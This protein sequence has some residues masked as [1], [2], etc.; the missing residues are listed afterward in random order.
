MDNKIKK[1]TPRCTLCK[2][3][4]SSKDD[5]GSG[6]CPKCTPY[7][8]KEELNMDNQEAQETQVNQETHEAQDTQE[9][10]I[11]DMA[12]IDKNLTE[13]QGDVTTEQKENDTTE[14]EKLITPGKRGVTNFQ[15]IPAIKKAIAA[16]SI[17]DL[18]LL[19]KHYFY[20]F[21]SSIRYLG[22]KQKAFIEANMK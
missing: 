6:L 7:K 8:K 17:E 11:I 3:L 16:V 14:I 18:K 4:Y 22:K 12:V 10:T 20:I 19:R 13:S 5:D 2:R 21:E 15:M 9:K 1:V